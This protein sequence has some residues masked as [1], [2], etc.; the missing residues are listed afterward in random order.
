MA[1]NPFDQFDGPAQA[2]SLQRVGPANAKTGLDA[3]R[4]QQQIQQGAATLPYEGPSAAASLAKTQQ[5][6]ADRPFERGDKL[7]SDF[8]A[9]PAVKNYREALTSLMAGINAKPDAAGDNAL[10]Y[11]YAKAMDPGSV[12]RESEMGMA[13]GTDS[14]ANSVIAKLKKQGELD[15]G[16]SLS[17]TARSRLKREMNTKVAQQAKAYG[18]ARKDYQGAAQRQGVNP[19]DVVGGFPGE[20]FFKKYDQLRQRGFKDDQAV[21]TAAAVEQRVGVPAASSGDGGLSPQDSDFL[22]KNARALGPDGLR[23]YVAARGL[24]VPE[25]NITALF[26]YYSKGGTQNPEVRAPTA[27]ENSPIS[28]G[29]SGVN[30]GIAST[31]GAPVDIANAAL[32]LGAQGINALAG[33]DLSVSDNPVLGSDWIRQQMAGAGS[34]GPE[35]Q[36]AGMP[37]VRRVGQSVG[38][39]AIP[40]GAGART[41]GQAGGMLASAL[42][43][44]IGAASAQQVAPGNPY[45]E[46]AGELIGGGVG[47]VGGLNNIRRAGQ[48]QIESAVPTI[49]QL[50]QQ[51]RGLY[52][53]AERS[54]VVASP[55][56]TQQLQGNLA[57]LLRDEG[58]LS[59]TDRI[60]DVM[61]N[62]KEGF[63][64]VGDYAGQ[65]MNPTQMQTV[66]RV[67]GEL[68]PTATKGEQRIAGGM[69][70]E[71]DQWANPM[72]PELPQARAIAS[73]YINAGKIA[74]A[75]KLANARASQFTGSGL[76]NALRTEFRALDRKA[77]KGQDRGLNQ[78]VI[79]AIEK[80][81]RGTV[82]SNVARGI[83][84]L[85]PT[86]S[87]SFGLGTVAPA[88]VGTM[89]AG[90]VGGMAAGALTGG[91]GALGRVAAEGMANRSAGLAELIARNGGALPTPQVMTPELERLIAAGLI[92]QQSQYLNGGNQ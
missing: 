29:L 63:N 47:A 76:E 44:G 72:A 68:P 36:Q 65:P 43:G 62:V 23:Q 51:A 15:G 11:A 33:T 17:S 91:A 69:L 24:Q 89:M 2:P 26:D 27:Y 37:F 28:Q 53:Q 19:E 20:P 21:R 54:G 10:I 52:Q 9:L 1:Q 4:A 34:I 5:A 67:L 7:R 12:V 48:A 74:E 66:R 38:A 42:G 60:T 79:D 57:Q 31:L 14:F 78:D 82:G 40:M 39:S 8:N 32:G 70:D 18:V 81:S 85:A 64:L 46:M 49:D 30:E 86:G 61:P 50:K 25:E 56:Q 35:S 83:G 16:G 92:G 59:P 77:V 41:L 55:A 71:F 73:R 22:S 80:V 13:S 84:R 45:A 6:V 87:V 3:T 90:P 58:R 75:R 88:A